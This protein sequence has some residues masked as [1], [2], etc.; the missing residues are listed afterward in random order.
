MSL[1][2]KDAYSI[3]KRYFSSQ[4]NSVGGWKLGGTNNLS[5]EAFNTTSLAFGFLLS[6]SITDDVAKLNLVAGSFEVELAVK[7]PDCYDESRTYSKEEIRKW[8]HFFSLEFPY[9]SINDLAA[10][11][12]AYL[13]ADNC[14]AGSLFLGDV[15]ISAPADKEIAFDL[16]VGDVLSEPRAYLTSC[17]A[18]LVQNFLSAAKDNGFSVLPGQLIATGGLTPLISVSR[19]QRY[20]IYYDGEKVLDFLGS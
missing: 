9:A 18:A 15:K 20:S 10:K 6:N 4:I 14:A 12:L 13:I 11:G 8:S 7:L 3:Q 19:G 16:F 5:Q 1:N 2:L 17:P